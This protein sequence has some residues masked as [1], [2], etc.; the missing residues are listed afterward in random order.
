[1][2]NLIQIIA[3]NS[4][5]SKHRKAQNLTLLFVTDLIES[6]DTIWHPRW[7][8]KNDLIVFVF[9]I[10]KYIVEIPMSEICFN[11]NECSFLTYN[12]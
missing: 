1:M 9:F 12:M 7:L 4:S 10:H 3:S 2:M 8:P 6:L 11:C 5:C